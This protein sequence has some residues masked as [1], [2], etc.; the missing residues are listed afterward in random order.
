MN[1]SS[2]NVQDITCL[3]SRRSD[4]GIASCENGDTE[5]IVRFL[6]TEFNYYDPHCPHTTIATSSKNVNV[7]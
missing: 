6:S 2:V 5:R 4:T 7:G 1:A 3:Y